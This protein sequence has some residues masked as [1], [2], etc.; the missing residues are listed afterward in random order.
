MAACQEFKNATYSREALAK[1]AAEGRTLL[2]GHEESLRLFEGTILK[3]PGVW[4]RM[5]E[6]AVARQNNAS[7]NEYGDAVLGNCA[8]LG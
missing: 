4:D 5:H 1:L 7:G 3:N 8:R 6:H 2:A